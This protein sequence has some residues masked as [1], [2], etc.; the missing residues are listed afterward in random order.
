MCVSE[1]PDGVVRLSSAKNARKFSFLFAAAC[2]FGMGLSA[3]SDGGEDPSNTPE[4]SSTDPCPTGQFCNAQNVCEHEE[5][6]ECSDEE[7]C[8]SGQFCN[9]S[10]TCENEVGND[11]SQSDPCPT[12]QICN[13]DGVCESDPG[14][15]ASGARL[16]DVI[17]EP[18]GPNCPYGGQ[19]LRT[20]I[21]ANDNGELDSDEV[22]GVSYVCAQ[23]S[24]GG[25]GFLIDVETVDAGD[26][27]CPDG[28]VIIHSGYD[29][30]DNGELDTD[31]RQSSVT[32]CNS[33][34][35]D[36]ADPLIIQ[37][38]EVEPDIFGNYDTGNVY[39]VRVQ[40]NRDVDASNLYVEQ[41]NQAFAPDADFAWNVDDDDARLVWIDF[42]PSS[43]ANTQ[44]TIA[45]DCAI[46]TQTV[47]LPPGLDASLNVRVFTDDF[48]V[49]GQD[50]EICWESRNAVSCKM[51][52]GTYQN[53]DEVQLPD[54]HGCIDVTVLAEQIYN[55]HY[56]TGPS[57][58]C[59]NSDAET[60]QYTFARYLN[61]GIYSFAPVGS[62]YGPSSGG[63]FS[64]VT[65]S[66]GMESCELVIN[67]TRYD[68]PANTQSTPIYLTEGG[69]ATLECVDANDDVYIAG[70]DNVHLIAVG[71][72]ISH[73]N[74][75]TGDDGQ[76]DLAVT[77]NITGLHIMDGSCAGT[78][79]YDGQTADLPAQS[80]QPLAA[81]NDYSGIISSNDVFEAIP[82][83]PSAEGTIEMT[84]TD[85]DFS[86]TVKQKL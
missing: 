53:P 17:S 9:D 10:N 50:I 35:C 20:G 52:K 66:V 5:G 15:S 84:C 49:A 67:D 11:C 23:N 71:P 83:N 69:Q 26:A 36:D 48:P 28:G 25:T 2:M 65:Q 42:Q 32:Q 70:E 54:V 13:D 73:F 1:R 47:M 81:P 3:C 30:N 63:A 31:E 64:F 27:T 8:P 82:Y 21:D 38:V 33:D 43:Y 86:Q 29:D 41:Y 79:T 22:D 4:C 60:H 57:V 44:L 37:T 34:A 40:L 46:A 39:K 45:D 72:G 56:Y 62:N 80:W 77:I 12:G 19:A 61:E 6:G 85:G 59:E 51:N 58:T 76:G 7:P 24:S 18:V 68:F 75:W 16:N 78:L 74:A 55:N 14:T